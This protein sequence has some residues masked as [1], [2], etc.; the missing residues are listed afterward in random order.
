MFHDFLKNIF[1]ANPE[2][3]ELS[4]SKQY[5]YSKDLIR[6]KHQLG[7]NQV[8]MALLL[9]IS[10]N[11]YLELE[12]PSIDVPLV[13]YEEAFTRL[14]QINDADISAVLDSP[15]DI[16]NSFGNFRF[17]NEI[18]ENSQV[19]AP[20][21]L[22]SSQ[23]FDFTDVLDAGIVKFV[24][25][26]VNDHVS[27]EKEYPLEMDFPIEEVCIQNDVSINNSIQFAA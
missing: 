16:M 22:R 8:Q 26:R 19:T 25:E 12:F 6:T 1:T 23:D 24:S 20:T 21:L 9:S 10:Y 3:A 14:G 5:K 18:N 7:I 11:E 4:N 17:T 13:K 2:F 15:L 27:G